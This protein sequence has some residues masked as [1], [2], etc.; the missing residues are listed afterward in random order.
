MDKFDP[1]LVLVN[2]N[3]LKHYQVFDDEAQIT[4]G[5]KPIYWGGRCDVDFNNKEEDNDGK[6]IYMVQIQHIKEGC[7][8]IEDSYSVKVD[9]DDIHFIWR[10]MAVGGVIFQIM[11]P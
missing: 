11:K 10:Y 5:P 9:L 3:K 6:L 2:V 7:N 4:W 1:N 8:T